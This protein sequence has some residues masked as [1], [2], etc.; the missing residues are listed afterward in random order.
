M[1]YKEAL[2]IIGGVSRPSKMPWFSWSISAHKCLTGG[3]LH[4]VKDS[5]CSSCYALKGR[6]LFPNVKN[7]MERR[8]NALKN[9]KFVEAF[10]MVL[11]ELF[12]RGQIKRGELKENRMR[13][14]DSGDLQ[15]LEHL[16]KIVDVSIR[17]PFIDH[18]LPTREFGI[19]KKWIKENPKGFPSNLTVRLSATIIGKDIGS[20]TMKLPYSTVGVTSNMLYQ[21]PA[22]FQDGKCGTCDKC[23]KKDVNVNYKK[24]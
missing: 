1:E 4:K 24:H 9:P 2:D 18:W 17:T 19:V 3:K 8:Y 14:H 11:T 21:C 20:I 23:W 13:W 10:T 6:Y 12:T 15:D 5:T 7:A 22:S 16:Q